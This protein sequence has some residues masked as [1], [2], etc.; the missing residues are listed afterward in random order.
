MRILLARKY[1]SS[2][3]VTVFI[4]TDGLGR[5]ISADLPQCPVFLPY[6]YPDTTK[7]DQKEPNVT[8]RKCL[9]NQRM[10]GVLHD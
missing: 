4:D 9:K 8:Y 6:L 2:D 1:R 7:S 3:L 5:Q 10:T